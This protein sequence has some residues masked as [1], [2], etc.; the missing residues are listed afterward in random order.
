MKKANILEHYALK[1]RP[2]LHGGGRHATDQ[3]ISLLNLVGTE[4]ILEIGFGTGATQVR[5]KSLYPKID[6]YG[7]ELSSIM[8]EQSRKR[9][10]FAGLLPTNLE[11]LDQVNLKF[12]YNASTF[13]VVLYESVLSIL[14][15]DE[16]KENL[17]EVKRVLKPGGILAL[18]ESIWL[19]SITEQEIN[20]I[21]KYCKNK[22]GIHL[23]QQ[24]LHSM[25]NW[26]NLFLAQQ[27]E[28]VQVVDVNKRFK[29]KTYSLKDYFSMIFS[30]LGKVNPTIGG[31]GNVYKKSIKELNRTLFR[32]KK[33]I[34]A[35]IFLIKST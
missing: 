34:A 15:L 1:N 10:K 8:M 14:S 25:Q 5:L 6:L 35:K 26:Q 17:K 2:Y 29:L 27:F 32:N 31:T 19:D 11:L 3:M 33:F 12:P 30:Y 18:N 4:K 21:N 16:I 23:A 13:D 7:L 24:E 28:M 9:F 20:E 22:F